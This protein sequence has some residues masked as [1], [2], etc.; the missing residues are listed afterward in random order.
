MILSRSDQTAD[1]DDNSPIRCMSRPS[2]RYY[3]EKWFRNEKQRNFLPTCVTKAISSDQIAVIGSY[4]AV[5]NDRAFVYLDGLG[6]L[7]GNISRAMGSTIVMDIDMSRNDRARFSSK[8]L[9][10]D[11]NA[12]YVGANRRA[13]PRYEPKNPRSQLA[14]PGSGRTDCLVS[15]VSPTGALVVSDLRP[16]IK[17]KVILGRIHGE[18]I[19]HVEAGFAIEFLTVQ[20]PGLLDDLLSVPE[21]GA[22]QV[23]AL[24][25]GSQIS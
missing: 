10:L 22:T 17:T 8:M 6:L 24:S 25:H 20:N 11:L 18:I 19:R 12:G 3:L 9:W 15:N 4:P 14:L 23:L 16:D 7:R 1:I 13:F 21:D 2:G 5:L